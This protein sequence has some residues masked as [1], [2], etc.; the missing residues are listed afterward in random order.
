MRPTFA[1]G[2]MIIRPISADDLEG[3]SQLFVACFSAP[4]WKEKWCISAAHVRISRMI[5]SQ[6][7]RG[8]VAVLDSSIVGMAFGQ[9][10]GWLDGNLFL[11]QEFCV[12]PSHQHQGIGRALLSELLTD[13]SS[14][15]NVGAVYLLTDHASPA[16]SFYEKFGF[17][18]SAKKVVM[19]A[20]ISSLIANANANANA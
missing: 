10:E 20:A 19:G 18:P 17:V 15:D 9:I 12:S 6:S 2:Q 4:P 1:P 14:I 16:Q 11:L 13:L 5:Q 8:V 7:C 3:L